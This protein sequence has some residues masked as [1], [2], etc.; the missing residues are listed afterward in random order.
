M[1]A[2]AEPLEV[3]VEEL[4][5][6]LTNTEIRAT[7]L[8]Y[9]LAE[10]QVA[11]DHVQPD[12]QEGLAA[13]EAQEAA[14]REELRGALSGVVAGVGN[15]LMETES[16]VQAY[17]QALIRMQQAQD[18]RP[19]V[20]ALQIQSQE[21]LNHIAAEAQERVTRVEMTLSTMVQAQSERFA[22]WE[23]TAAQRQQT[24]DATLRALSE[25]VQGL[26]L[27]VQNQQ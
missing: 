14:A 22:A 27:S 20:A 8:R 2:A 15:R 7:V 10:A 16:G 6:R 4:A 1:E 21:S 5:E 23:T 12:L 13:V 19:M 17:L 11:L 26:R 18:P 3:R 9:G 24:L 25:E